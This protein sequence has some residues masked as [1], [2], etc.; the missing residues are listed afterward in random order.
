MH[1]VHIVDS[2]HG[3]A[4]ELLFSLL[5]Y[6]AVVDVIKPIS[7][8]KLVF[9]NDV[10]LERGQSGHRSFVELYLDLVASV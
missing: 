8:T 7:V 1:S 9:S 4:G 2:G 10:A 5:H 3:P 6:G